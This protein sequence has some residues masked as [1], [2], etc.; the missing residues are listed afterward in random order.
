MQVEIQTKTTQTID[1]KKDVIEQIGNGTIKDYDKG[2]ILSWDV[3]A[4]SLHFQMTVLENKILLKNQ[5]QDMIFELGRTTKSVIHTQY[6]NLK[7][8]IIT[9]HID[10]IKEKELIKRIDLV[11]DIQ[12][13]DTMKYENK[14]EISIKQE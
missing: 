13:E 5:N 8:N 12:I 6:G 7:I 4:E 3:P 14:I 1:G 10:V 11:Y 9:K 2:T